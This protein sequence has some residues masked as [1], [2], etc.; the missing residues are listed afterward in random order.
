MCEKCKNL[1]ALHVH[2]DQS[3]ESLGEKMASMTSKNRTCEAPWQ[4]EKY[5]DVKKARSFA[6]NRCESIL[7]FFDDNDITCKSKSAD[8]DDDD[9][10]VTTISTNESNESKSSEVS[11]NS[12]GNG[13]TGDNKDS[14][15]VETADDDGKNIPML[16]PRSDGT[17]IRNTSSTAMG[18]GVPSGSNDV[19][20]SGDDDDLNR[21]ETVDFVAVRTCD[22]SICIMCKQVVP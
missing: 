8:D 18:A 17:N 10:T 16:S 3:W 12:K 19:G 21:V 11:T 13:T 4:R 20:P 22:F 15:L 14:N 1:I 6:K 5:I 9:A 2:S 7:K